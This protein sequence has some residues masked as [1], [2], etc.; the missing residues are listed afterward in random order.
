MKKLALLLLLPLQL[1]SQTNLDSL[2]EKYSRATFDDFRQL[3]AIPCDAHFP[4]EIEK[5]VQ[6]AEAAFAE[7]NFTHVRL[8]TG[9]ETPL[10]LAQRKCSNPNAK[11]VLAYLQLDGQPVD[12]SHWFQESPWE[13]VLKEQREGEG[14]VDIP[15]ESLNGELNLDWRIFAR[16][17]SDAK[18][19][20]M[21]FLAAIDALREMGKEPDYHLKVIMDFE[22]E[23]GSPHLPKAVEKHREALAADVLVIF[24]G[25]RHVSNQPTLAFGARGIADLTLTVFG[26]TFPQ[27]SG[28]YGNYCPNPALR[29]AQLLASMKDAAGRV[30]IPGF[31]DGVFLDE[32]TK[33]ILAQ[34]PDDEDFIK[35][36][37]G[38][39]Q[40]DQVASNLQEALQFPSLNV[41]GMQSAWIGEE[42]RTIIPATATA[43]I[44]M[45]LVLESDPERLIGLVK[46]HIEDQGYLVLDRKPTSRERV[47]HD[48]IC[49]FN[50]SVSYLAYRTEMDSE[51][52]QWLSRAM[53]KAFDR[54]PVMI[55][56][57][58][59]S[60]PISPFVTTLGVPAVSVPTV[61]PDNNQHSPNENIRIG[62]YVDGVK[63]VLAILLEPIG[64]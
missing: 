39:A 29:L 15:W 19:P 18:G 7:R 23:L 30:T 50:S 13:A 42:A 24:D 57:M 9:A 11:T 58:G 49:Q 27:H 56:T 51:A 36:K 62:N 47:Q 59:G 61:N 63:T 4:K 14:W 1:L 48:R 60:I 41:R 10:L 33:T 53:V 37:L 17:T 6:W 35:I 55:R 40:P 12:F 25:P 22:E 44:D 2:A 34:V 8:E 43:E 28:H 31:Y 16:A 32:K 5:N 52:G 20:V 38:V 3:L 46:K 64:E 26:P 21:M 54:K 45:R